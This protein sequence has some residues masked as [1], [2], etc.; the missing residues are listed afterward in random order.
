MLQL[1]EQAQIAA[2][3][4]DWPAVIDYLQQLSLKPSTNPSAGADDQTQQQLVDLALQ[5]LAYGDFSTRWDVAKLMPRLGSKAIAPLVAIAQ[6]DEADL[7]ER[8][9][10][11][12]LLGEFNTP[13]VINT[14]VMLLKEATDPDL[15]AIAAHALADLGATAIEPL[16]KLL[17]QPQSCLLATSALVQIPNA[18]VI[19]PLLTVVNHSDA[20]IRAMAID[21]LSNFQDQR[22][23]PV[24]LAALQDTAAPVRKVAVLGLGLRS[25][26]ATELQLLDHMQP[27]LHDL[28]LEVCQQAAIALGR[29]KTDAAAAL[30]F[31]ELQSSLTPLPLK[32]TLVRA[33]AWIESEFALEC[34]Q[35]ALSQ[36][37]EPT[38]L[39]IIQ[40]LGRVSMESC[41][42]LAAEILLTFFNTNHPTLST[43]PVKQALAHAWELLG[44]P[45]ATD[46]LMQLQQDAQPIVSIHARSALQRLQDT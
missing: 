27:L 22:I 30:L 26:L 24:L 19:T 13:E 3:Q 10:A 36:G 39:E 33:L 28:N 2:Q 38:V 46:A 6:D 11:G 29:L 25:S 21:A 40:V 7:E 35:R 43:T 12:R 44:D 32:I 14:L 18:A 31:T 4:N 34:L 1:L 45:G 5:V 41:K 37:S 9:F 23:P 20:K 8:W 17:Q 16:A 42:P 15:A